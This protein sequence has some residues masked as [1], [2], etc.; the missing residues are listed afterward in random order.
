M[1]RQQRVFRRLRKCLLKGGLTMAVDKNSK[2]YSPA[3]ARMK[4]VTG[5]LY[6][7]ARDAKAAGLPVGFS[8][9][10]FPKEIFEVFDLNVIY[11]ENHA[12]AVAAHKGAIPFCEKAESLGYSMD[13]CSYARINLGF[14]EREEEFGFGLDIPQ[15]DFLCVCNNI[16]TTVL[17]WYENLAWKLDIPLIMFDI[18]Y[19]TDGYYKKDKILYIK[20][21]IQ[22]VVDQ[23]EKITGKQFDYDRFQDVMETSSLNGKLFQEAL[24]LIGKT[25]PSPV[26]G[27]DAYNYMAL[28]VIARGRKETTEVLR[29]Y[30]DELKDKTAKGESSFDGEE[31]HR[32][33]FDGLC[34]WPYLRSNSETLAK[35]GINLVGT[36]YCGN[37]GVSFT[38]LYDMCEKYASTNNATGIELGR[39]Y[40]VQMLDDYHCDGVLCNVMRS[41]KPWVGIMFEMQRQLVKERGLPY[42]TFDADQAD[43]RVFSQAQFETRVQG[44]AEIMDIREEQRA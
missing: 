33:M 30:I 28:M 21:Q 35:N 41:C 12:A 31:K 17:K 22:S 13:L 34:C 43:P 24:D 39:D 44:L 32:I 42:A 27:F 29:M 15:P 4:E 40:R 20:K 37:Y 10:N 38:D 36:P 2:K 9:S 3:R 1:N 11:P 14:V 7:Q 26:S 16:C 6:Q 25:K 18:P 8:T 5:D 19:N 23:L